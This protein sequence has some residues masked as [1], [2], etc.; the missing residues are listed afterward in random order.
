MDLRERH[1]RNNP[2]LQDLKSLDINEIYSI[3][4]MFISDHID[5]GRYADI[6][7]HGKP[8]M[9]VEYNHDRDITDVEYSIWFYDGI[10]VNLNW[11]NVTLDFKKE[12][13]NNERKID[14]DFSRF[15]EIYIKQYN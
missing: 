6:F 7:E 12:H 13:C 2:L 15:H 11:Y 8:K 10:V 9:K 14:M 1:E 4:D 5:K 3:I